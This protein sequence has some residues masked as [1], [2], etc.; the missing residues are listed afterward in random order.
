MEKIKIQ[1]T[2]YEIIRIMPTAPN[3]LQIVF[4]DNIPKE[5]GDITTFTIGGLEAGNISGY[6]TLYRTDGQTIY[7]SNDGS[8]YE[9]PA[10]SELM[11][12]P[13]LIKE[14]QA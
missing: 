8:V 10:D 1:D 14:E 2:E 12:E 6:H 9:P 4:A 13:M 5:W 3:V 11:D 7:L